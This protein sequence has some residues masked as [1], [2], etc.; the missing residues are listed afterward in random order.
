MGEEYK[1]MYPKQFYNDPDTKIAFREGFTGMNSDS[2]DYILE[3]HAQYPL[4]IV[5]FYDILYLIVLTI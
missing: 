2:C 5:L 1:E 3:H 4:T